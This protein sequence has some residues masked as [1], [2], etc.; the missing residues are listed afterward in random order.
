MKGLIKIKDFPSD[1][2]KVFNGLISI[3]RHAISKDKVCLGIA[4][5]SA[6]SQKV[7]LGD[8]SIYD[9][10]ICNASKQSTW[11]RL[12][13][14]IYLHDN[15]VH[16]EGHY[17]YFEKAIFL[18]THETQRL[19]IIYN[20]KDCASIEIDEIPFKPDVFWYGNGELKGKYLVKALLLDRNKDA[21]D[22][23][24]LVQ[25]LST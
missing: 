11:V 1:A 24:T 17:G 9:L 5:F 7:K 18:R 23:R 4:L 22:E 6:L 16:P 3:F 15:C 21:Y 19:H 13:I 8:N 25:Y 20:W 2:Y 10:T 14:D 12:I